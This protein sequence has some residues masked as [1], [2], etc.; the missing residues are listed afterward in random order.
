M[1]EPVLMNE[2]E[3]WKEWHKSSSDWR[4]WMYD[5]LCDVSDGG[6]QCNQGAFKSIYIT[7]LCI[8]SLFIDT[9]ITACNYHVPAPCRGYMLFDTVEELT[10]NRQ[11]MQVG[12][13]WLEMSYNVTHL[14][15]HVRECELEMESRQ[16]SVHAQLL[17]LSTHAPANQRAVCAGID[18]NEGCVPRSAW[19]TAHDNTEWC[20]PFISQ[21]I[22]RP[23]H[24]WLPWLR[25]KTFPCDSL[26]RPWLMWVSKWVIALLNI[27]QTHSL[28]LQTEKIEIKLN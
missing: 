12:R 8:F 25:D 19:T 11:I 27:C 14:S 18:R 4:R 9:S 17:M 13:R 15:T 24:Q 26:I 5:L 21:H 2:S 20:Q 7:H 10:R 1:N 3:R 16:G 22:H 6:M 23:C 28:C